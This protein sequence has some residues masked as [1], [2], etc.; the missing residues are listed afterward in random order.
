M[1]ATPFSNGS[2]PSLELLDYNDFEELK[3]FFECQP[4]DF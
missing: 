1:L 4:S 2:F 3:N